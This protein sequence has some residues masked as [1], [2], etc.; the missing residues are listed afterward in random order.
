[1][2]NAQFIP[3]AQPAPGRSER[4]SARPDALPRTDP[5]ASVGRAVPQRRRHAH[6]RCN[7]GPTSSRS[8]L[9]VSTRRVL[10]RSATRSPRRVRSGVLGAGPWGRSHGFDTP[11]LKGVGDGSATCTTAPPPRPDVLTTANATPSGNTASLKPSSCNTLRVLHQID[12]RARPRVASSGAS[13]KAPRTRP[14]FHPGHL[15]AL[16][17]CVRRPRVHVHYRAPSSRA[18]RG[19]TANDSNRSP[20]IPRPLSATARRTSTRLNDRGPGHVGAATC[21]TPARSV[22]TFETATT[23]RTYS[24]YRT[25]FAVGQSRPGPAQR[26]IMY[27]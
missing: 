11:T 14:M 27:S 23:I 5:L 21:P 2:T 9:Q 4:V 13:V 16:R 17:N 19:S 10:Q 6:H 22:V 1:M 15:Q 26:A 12:S 3:D 20:A 18:R 8:R 24:V 7:G 25:R